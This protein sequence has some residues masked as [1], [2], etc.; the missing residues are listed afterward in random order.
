MVAPGEEP[1]GGPVIGHAGI[2]VADG[3][4]EELQEAPDGFVA[5]GGD[6]MGRQD[7]IAGNDHE[8]F[9]LRDC[10]LS[11]TSFMLR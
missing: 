6:H 7:P 5:R 11:I 3:G 1:R 8:R 4:G 2:F 9:G 10:D